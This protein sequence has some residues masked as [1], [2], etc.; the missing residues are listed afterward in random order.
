MHM[1]YVEQTDTVHSSPDQWSDFGGPGKALPSREIAAFF[2]VQHWQYIC[3]NCGLKKERKKKQGL[4]ALNRHDT[5]HKQERYYLL[6]RTFTWNVVVAH[7]TF[8]LSMGWTS[9]F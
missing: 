2:P 5:Q 8:P 4:T 3:L 7:T 6:L 9:R 1:I